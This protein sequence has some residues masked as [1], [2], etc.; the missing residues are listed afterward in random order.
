[1]AGRSAPE[2]IEAAHRAR[3]GAIRADDANVRATHDRADAGDRSVRAGSRETFG[4]GLRYREGELVVLAACHCERL[5]LLGGEPTQ[6]SSIRYATR[7]DDG[8]DPAGL[9]NVTE[10]LEETVAHVDGGARHPLAR[11]RGAE[12]Q[13]VHG[14]AERQGLAPR[15]G[16]VAE[17]NLAS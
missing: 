12:C 1:K 4:V 3:A 8:A 9:T 17:Q 13:P 2:M 11:E 7:V 16:A 10:I 15:A 5:P 14:T 6:T